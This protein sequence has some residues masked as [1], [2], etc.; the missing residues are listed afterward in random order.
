[1]SNKAS[2]IISVESP[3]Q[4]TVTG[5]GYV[6]NLKKRTSYG[7]KEY[8]FYLD[9]GIV[10]GGS[11]E[12]DFKINS[13]PL[14]KELP[15]CAFILHGHEDH[16]GNIPQLGNRR[17]DCPPIYMS[18]GT[19]MIQKIARPNSKK[20]VLEAA[21]KL[22]KRMPYTE[23]AIKKAMD[24]IVEVSSF[25]PFKVFDST[26][27]A[28]FA[29]NP[30]LVGASLGFFKVESPNEYEKDLIFGYLS[31]CKKKNS[32]LDIPEI[33]EQIT[34]SL[35]MLIDDSDTKNK[36]IT[37]MVL[38]STYGDSTTKEVKAGTFENT[39][40]NFFKEEPEGI[41]I[42]LTYSLGRNQDVLYALKD[43]Q[44]KNIL[45]KNIPI[46]GNGPLAFKYDNML[47]R[48]PEIFLLKK[49]KKKFQT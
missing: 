30:H 27:T 34:R 33:S 31:D 35:G 28:V 7:V 2:I 23:Q 39:I 37:F 32:A 8:R 25:K 18:H 3:H 21:K 26:M 46:F 40:S 16:A 11:L 20:I 10:Q 49:R 22:Q 43:L 5:S 1:M 9:C 38:D 19:A 48:N 36:E 13:S 12:N 15:D 44:N 41:L 4:S 29:D 24:S 47:E 42:I 6:C 17:V 45:D 14:T